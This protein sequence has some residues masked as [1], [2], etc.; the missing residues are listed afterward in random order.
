MSL[1]SLA[2]K[3]AALIRMPGPEGEGEAYF[4]AMVMDADIKQSGRWPPWKPV[5]LFALEFLAASKGATGRVCEL[6]LKGSRR[7]YGL[8]IAADR[9]IFLKA[10]EPLISA[11]PTQP[12]PPAPAS[13][14]QPAP[15]PAPPARPPPPPPPEPPAPE[16]DLEMAAMLA[17]P[18]FLAEPVFRKDSFLKLVADDLLG[19]FLRGINQSAED[20]QVWEP[21]AVASRHSFMANVSIAGKKRVA[22]VWTYDLDVDG[23]AG[24]DGYVARAQKPINEITI[25]TPSRC[26]EEVVIN[27][28][29]VRIRVE[30]GGSAITSPPGSQIV[31]LKNIGWFA[32]VYRPQMKF[33]PKL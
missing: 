29:V 13:P 27:R 16:I 17:E 24:Y 23:G 3:P 15:P 2:G 33:R 31:K 22:L 30:A 14:P 19:D 9:H 28:R 8:Q 5:R 7:D 18:E 10:I 26:L 25:D 4:V 12:A 6:G 21:H 32:A 11:P 20:A 1:H